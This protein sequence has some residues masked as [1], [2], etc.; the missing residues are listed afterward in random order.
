MAN[1]PAGSSPLVSCIMPTYNRRSLVAQSIRYFLRQDYESRE[2]LIID[3]GPDAIGDLVP[4]DPR[5]RYFRLPSKLSIGA[6]RNLACEEARGD[7]ILH[8]DDDDW[9]A[10]HRISYQVSSLLQQ[11]SDLCGLRIVLFYDRHKHQAWRY[12]YPAA[13]RFWV[14]GNSFCYRREFWQRNRFP[15]VDVGEDTRMLW[16][17]RAGRM[18]G[19]DDHSVHVSIMHG[20][21]VSAREAG[22]PWWTPQSVDD[23]ARLLGDDF[24]FYTHDDSPT[25]AG[26][27]PAT[28]EAFAIARATDLALPEFAAFNHA[29]NLP[30][31]RRW[32]L[33][34]I[35]FDARLDNTMSVLNCTINP[36]GLQ[37]R[38][39]ALYPNV[40]YR[41][42]NPLPGQ[43]LALP[44]GVPDAAFDRVFCINTLEHLTRA[45]RELLI[46][47]LAR[48]LKPGGRLLFTSDYYFDS[49]WSDPAFLNAGVMRADRAEFPGGWNKITPAEWIELCAPHGLEP[50]AQA[51][52]PEPSAGDLSYY[53]HPAPFPHAAIGGSF[54][55][56]GVPPVEPRRR[57]VLGLLSWNT[58]A[59]VLDSVRAYLREAHMLARLGHSA[60]VCICDNG[61]VD[62]TPQAL[63]ALAAS[64][65]APLHL[66]LNRQNRGNSVARNQ[67]ID[68]VLDSGADYVLFMD[69]DIEIVPFSSFAMLRYMENC[70]SQLGCIGADFNNQSP[71]RDR[72][73]PYVYSIA[74]ERVRDFELLA[75]TQYGLFRREV[76]LDGVRFDETA[77][78][79]GPGWGF[80]D[81][82]L[83]FQMKMRGYRNQYFSGMVYLHRAARS[84]VRVMRQQ[85]IEPQS[86]FE[87]R[88]AYVLAKWSAV[89]A[90]HHALLPEVRRVQIQL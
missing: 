77:P 43:D 65:A 22:G 51:S 74:P 25:P 89:P 49:S 55:K 80:E 4:A 7:L 28:T 64:G 32:E 61:S 21:N 8:W 11:G 3:D 84:S 27:E 17:A 72:V 6:K 16:A 70:G 5:I 9:H 82:D 29:I 53:R 85:G 79:D 12:E 30:H 60:T 88:K 35:L 15:D 48:K 23:I 18:I 63:E 26:P 34:R 10:P 69:G 37:E 40:L 31:M 81:N 59:I 75:W 14:H 42:W 58:R 90:I 47:A 57:V 39:A 20:A 76:F 38:L 45:Q 2:L 52:A 19:L 86:L 24:A 68:Y 54:V 44:F 1:S 73:T 78:F 67:I 36:I 13:E 50:A 83:A 33:P 66:I 87:Q 62:G 56:T 46:G 41:H 71:V